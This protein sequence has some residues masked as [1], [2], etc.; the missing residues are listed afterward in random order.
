MICELFNCITVTFIVSVEAF[1][2][3]I[4]LRGLCEV[5]CK[6][7]QVTFFLAVR[8]PII[9]NSLQVNVSDEHFEKVK[10]EIRASNF[11]RQ[12]WKQCSAKMLLEE[13]R[14]QNNMA[15]LLKLPS[16]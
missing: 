4:K 13:P 11:P 10:V 2:L 12:L 14:N 15:S 8:S 1:K 6:K 16:F 7:K 9:S 5:V 3:H